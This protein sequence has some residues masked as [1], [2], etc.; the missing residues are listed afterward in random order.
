MD[1]CLRVMRA[2]AAPDLP[3]ERGTGGGAA[4]YECGR[5]IRGGRRFLQT[6]AGH[7]RCRCRGAVPPLLAPGADA[8]P[9]VSLH[10]TLSH[11]SQTACRYGPAAVYQPRHFSSKKMSHPAD[12]STLHQAK[13]DRLTARPGLRRPA[14]MRKNVLNSPHVVGEAQR[15]ALKLRHSDDGRAHHQAPA[16]LRGLT[17]S[18]DIP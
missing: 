9:C 18:P 10:N 14:R 12:H 4:R 7:Q 1:A 6:H 2:E 8:G 13:H 5:R 17:K 15:M 3:A 16:T 11:L